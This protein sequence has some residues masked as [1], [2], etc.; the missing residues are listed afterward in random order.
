[1]AMTDNVIAEGTCL[2]RVSNDTVPRH[3]MIRACRLAGA[4]LLCLVCL[5]ADS[6][7]AQG[8]KYAG[9]FLR[10]GVGP[11]ALGMGGAFVAVADDVT[12][13]YWNPAGLAFLPNRVASVMHSEQLSGLAYDYAGYAHPRGDTE[14]RTA[15]GVSLIRLGLDDIPITSLPNPALPIDELLANGQRNRPFVVRFVGNVEYGLLLSY[16]RKASSKLAIGGNVKIIHKSLGVA[17]AFGVG[18]DA[19]VLFSPLSHLFVGANLQNVTSTILTWDTG[20][21]EYIAP[22]LKLGASYL[23]PVKQLRGQILFAADLD[24]LIE[25]RK[26]STTSFGRASGSGHFGV[27]YSLQRTVTIRT[28]VNS[29]GI[30]AGAGI[31]T[32][33][34]SMFSTML[35]PSIDYAFVN[36]S[37]FGAVHRVGA[38]VGF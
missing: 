27:E 23:L 16:A 32:P 35:I 19:S 38:S 10:I 22:Q 20:T 1:M 9:E 21:K 17:S 14:R 37:A 26:Q 18:V 15:Y 24:L 31:S 34:F 33:S 8:T 13:A 6:A 29:N 4:A 5:H 3:L 2:D 11:R 30:T 12:A 25:G 36:D 28:G 7:V